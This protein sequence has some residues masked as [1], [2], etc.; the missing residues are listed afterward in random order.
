MTLDELIR[1]LRLQQG[2]CQHLE[3]LLL[4][5]MFIVHLN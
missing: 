1:E 3:S 5:E 4:A 2:V